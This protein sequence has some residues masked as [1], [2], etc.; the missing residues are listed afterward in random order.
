MMIIN[1]CGAGHQTQCPDS[2]EAFTPEQTKQFK[3]SRSCRSVDRVGSVKVLEGCFFLKVVRTICFL[4]HLAYW[5]ESVLRLY[6][7]VLRLTCWLSAQDHSQFFRPLHS[8][9]NV[10]FSI[11][12]FIYSFVFSYFF[13]M[14][15]EFAYAKHMWFESYPRHNVQARKIALV[16]SFWVV[17]LHFFGQR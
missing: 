4:A 11:H 8:L 10:L 13:F 7:F 1:V 14:L 2:C 12:S 9:I 6:S 5:Q 16:H 15:E 3:Y 17:Q